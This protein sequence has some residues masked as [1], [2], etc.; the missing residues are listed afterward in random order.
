M[1]KRLNPNKGWICNTS[2]NEYVYDFHLSAYPIIIKVASSIS[3]NTDKAR[4]K[5][6]DAIRVYAVSK[7]NTD[8]DSKIV[9]GLIKSRRVNRNTNWRNDV[10]EKVLSVIK[11]A[12]FVYDK[13]NK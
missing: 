5:G 8:K 6:A 9:S 7:A 13:R 4:S 3:V 1:D 11:S 10:Q 12:K 2:G